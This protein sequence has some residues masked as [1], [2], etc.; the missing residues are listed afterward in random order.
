MFPDHG[1]LA[2]EATEAHD[3]KMAPQGGTWKKGEH[4]GHDMIG[5]FNNYVMGFID[6]NLI[7]DSHGGRRGTCSRIKLGLCLRRAFRARQD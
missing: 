1:I 5:D 2:T 3:S 6:W 7:L 4:Y